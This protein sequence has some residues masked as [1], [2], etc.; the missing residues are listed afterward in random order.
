MFG[1]SP[2]L[3]DE[4]LYC[5]D[6]EVVGF[7]W[8]GNGQAST[9]H[10]NAERYTVEIGPATDLLENE[11]V[12]LLASH[13]ANRDYHPPPQACVRQAKPVT[14]RDQ[15]LRFHTAAKIDLTFAAEHDQE[16]LA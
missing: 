10:F 8:D 3:A 2:G 12:I 5:A 4:V 7:K 1:A 6:T 13:L 9:E 15:L 14:D 16:S 11:R